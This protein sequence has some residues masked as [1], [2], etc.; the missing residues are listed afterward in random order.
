MH[1]REGEFDGEC[2]EK[3][4]FACAENVERHLKGL[5]FQQNE[6]FGFFGCVL[7]RKGFLSEEFQR[8]FSFSLI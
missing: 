1:F 2:C 5:S 4:G 6:L 3:Q 8:L 7:H